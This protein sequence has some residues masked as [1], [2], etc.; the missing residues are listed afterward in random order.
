MPDGVLTFSRICIPESNFPSFKN[1]NKPLRKPLVRVD[2][3]I[4]DCKG[5]LQVDFANK[6]IGGGVLNHGCV[7][8]EIRFVI[9]PE[10]LVSL[11]FSERMDS[12]EAILI[13]GAERF[14][15]YTGY[16][17]SFEWLE[18]YVDDTAR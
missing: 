16:A 13:R 18:D 12:N 4:E 15:S 5:A 3:T 7:Q 11:L 17:R 10:L 1:S 6:Y 8:E 14:S 9:C 2:G